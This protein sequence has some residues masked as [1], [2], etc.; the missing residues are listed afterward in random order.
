MEWIPLALGC[1]ES[2][3]AGHEKETAFGNEAEARA[4]RDALRCKPPNRA[5]IEW[6]RRSALVVIPAR[7]SEATL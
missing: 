4:Y 3:R 7:M 2:A 6:L 1:V 5:E